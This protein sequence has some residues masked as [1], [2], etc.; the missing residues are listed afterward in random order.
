MKRFLTLMMALCM[1]IVSGCSTYDAQTQSAENEQN[2]AQ[3]EQIETEMTLAYVPSAIDMP[4]H[5]K[6]IWG[7]DTVG[8]TIWIGCT[9]YDGTYIAAAYD[10]ISKSWQQYE[11]E[12]AD[13]YNP[14]PQSFSANGDSVWI[15]FK[16]SLTDLSGNKKI[17]DLKY[18]ISCID[19]K[20]HN[21]KCTIVP[22]D[23]SESSESSELIFCSIVAL[24]D[25]SALLTTYDE[26][27]LIDSSVNILNLIDSMSL[28]NLV[29]VK[30][31]D[32]L[33]IAT[34]DELYSFEYD[35]LSFKLEADLK[36]SGRLS[37]NNGSF[38][39]T[40]QRTLYKYN[41][42][43]GDKTEVFKWID[44]A[45]SYKD[46]G[47]SCVFENS[48][49]S[50][51]YPASDKI[52]EVTQ[53]QVPHKKALNLLCFGGTGEAQETIQ[54]LPY[55]SS[56]EL[57]DAVIRFNN[58]DTEYKI[59]VRTVTFNSETE[60]V[61][62]LVKLAT[63]D[64]VDIIDTSILPE[65]SLKSGFLLDMLP[66]IDSDEMISREDFIPSLLSAMMK[67][68]GLYEYTDKFTLLTMI[69]KPELYSNHAS[70]T[71]DEIQRLTEEMNLDC[72]CRESLLDNFVWA[73]SG[74]FIDRD[75]MTCSF[76]SENFRAW[77]EFLKALPSSVEGYENPLVFRCIYD[78]AGDA[79]TW[80]RTII[81]GEYTVSGFPNTES[82]G[83]YFI[84]LNGFFDYDS[85]TVGDNTRVG[86]LASSKAPEAAWRFVRT[87]M[88]KESDSTIAQGIPVIKSRFENALSNSISD[89]ASE[90]NTGVFTEN[91][92]QMMCEQV[93]GTSKM[94]YDDDSLL[95]IIRSEAVM[96]FEGQKSLDDTVSQIQSI[97]S[98]YLAEQFS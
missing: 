49:G 45:L 17:S 2:S 81:E 83:S 56:D 32:R 13:A 20:S 61:R 42:Q 27:Y 75:T 74:E 60:R 47:E 71:T 29:D 36:Y 16:E 78:F 93:Y 79:G 88:L 50:F 80:A 22:F 6:E 52:I 40:E 95:R 46:M 39:L 64:D 73:A 82:T 63:A 85:P 55:N 10:T 14:V 7:L 31:D 15:L 77:L 70:W 3:N 48:A 35:T 1:L 84:K 24:D 54:S 9:D 98:I 5:T 58:T 67:N 18:Y 72:E 4:E 57:I 69:T 94:V 19:A 62:L 76:D 87:L 21:S 34:G 37:S 90:R 65:N 96:Y 33:Y 59:N 28:G 51:Y 11:I 43:G 41:P 89:E 26:S 68:G 23:G 66:Y 44:V 38:L 25:S 92:A 91:D 53:Q 8:D 30:I 86:I 97:V 12:T